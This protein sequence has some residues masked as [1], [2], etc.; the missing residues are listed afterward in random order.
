MKRLKYKIGKFLD[1][2]FGRHKCIIVYD[3]GVLTCGIC[4]YCGHRCILDRKNKWYL[5]K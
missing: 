2:R 5:Y 3:D 1:K 4:K